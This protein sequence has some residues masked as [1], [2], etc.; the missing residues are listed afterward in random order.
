MHKSS[1]WSLI[2]LTNSNLKPFYDVKETA[3]CS[4]SLVDSKFTRK[5]GKIPP[6]VL[7]GFLQQL[8]SPQLF[9]RYVFW[10]GSIL[11]LPWFAREIKH[12]ERP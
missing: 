12:A 7:E 11:S 10:L 4:G 8:V 3:I 9:Q 5:E 1:S 2:S 6:L